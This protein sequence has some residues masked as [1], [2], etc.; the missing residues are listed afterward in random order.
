MATFWLEEKL[1]EYQNK[2]NSFAN[3]AVTGGVGRLGSRRNGMRGLDMTANGIVLAGIEPDADTV[4]TTVNL[5]TLNPFRGKRAFTF[6]ARHSVL[7]L[8]HRGSRH[9]GCWRQSRG[10]HRRRQQSLAR[11]P[12]PGAVYAMRERGRANCL[13]PE[14][15][16]ISRTAK[17]DVI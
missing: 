17:H 13:Q 6:G 8:P 10:V 7:A 11:E 4:S 9:T 5:N 2:L 16:T 3:L 15:A 1:S 12:D 14:S